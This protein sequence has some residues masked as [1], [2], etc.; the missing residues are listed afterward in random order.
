MASKSGTKSQSKSSG[1]TSSTKTVSKSSGAKS[2]SERT[3]NS[4]TNTWEGNGVT[5][6]SSDGSQ[7]NGKVSDKS[8]YNLTQEKSAIGWVP[9]ATKVEPVRQPDRTSN[10]GSPVGVGVARVGQPALPGPGGTGQVK[11]GTPTAGPGV[12]Q[13]AI[14]LGTLTVVG[15]QAGALEKPKSV[16]VATP[17]P[18][19]R[20]PGKSDVFGPAPLT[21]GKKDKATGGYAGFEVM[22]NPWFSN[23]E[24]FW[25]TR[26][27]E[28]GEWL[29]GILNIGADVVYNIPR[30]VD[31]A[32]VNRNTPYLGADWN[33]NLQYEE[34]P[35]LPE[36]EPMPNR[37]SNARPW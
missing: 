5:S 9:V 25:E 31:A 14:H 32:G 16:S 34:M 26:Y 23:V 8:S 12:P 29:G 2:V 7:S 30:A 33:P 17:R 19:G 4:G 13:T 37:R 20:G 11:A 22:P 15:Q 18:T 3:Y 28:P 36:V 1:E 27:G 6:F 35:G 10:S 24:D 21:P